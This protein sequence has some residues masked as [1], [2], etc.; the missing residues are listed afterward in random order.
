MKDA[1]IDDQ[2]KKANL[3]PEELAY[4][5]S[6]EPHTRFDNEGNEI[7]GNRAQRRKR[8]TTDSKYTKNTHSQQIKK[9]GRKKAR[10]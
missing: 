6:R 4:F 7:I 5:A 10:K 1:T 8:P 2:L 3:T 9:V